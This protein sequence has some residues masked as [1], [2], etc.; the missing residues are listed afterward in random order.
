MTER[1]R[2]APVAAL[3]SIGL[4]GMTS[5]TRAADALG[6]ARLFFAPDER[7]RTE[8]VPAPA[9]DTSNDASVEV[10][11]SARPASRAPKAPEGTGAPRHRIGF[12][13]LLRVGGRVRVVVGGRPCRGSADGSELQ[14]GD[15]P[16]AVDTLALAA[17]GRLVVTL[18][19]GSRRRVSVG[20]TLPP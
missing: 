4:L 16:A 3:L 17:D 5:S 15:V 2:I 9:N 8:G 19:D 7:A 20:G 14:C 18:R 6:D 13:A 10:E 1:C 12:D 11:A